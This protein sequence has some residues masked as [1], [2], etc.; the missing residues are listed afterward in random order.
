MKHSTITVLGAGYVGLSTAALLA[1]AGFKVYAIEP[2]KERLEVIKQGRSFFY[3]HGLDP[4]VKAAMDA[5][6]L[7]ATDSYEDSIPNSSVIFSCVGTPDNPDGSS[8][9]MGGLKRAMATTGYVDLKSFQR[10]DAIVSP[11]SQQD[12]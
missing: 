5:G 3:E 10:V 6:S 2:N 4:V 8:N 12:R 7:I 9:L 1:N 11:L